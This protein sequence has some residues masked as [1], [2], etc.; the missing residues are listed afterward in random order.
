M[1]T[2]RIATRSSTKVTNPNTDSESDSDSAERQN[3]HQQQQQQQHRRPQNSSYRSQAAADTHTTYTKGA[4][5]SSL[6]VSSGPGGSFTLIQHRPQS[7]SSSSSP[8]SAVSASV[9]ASASAPISL[10]I[11]ESRQNID[12]SNCQSNLN[13]NN[14][15]TNSGGGSGAGSSESTTTTTGTGTGVRTT[16]SRR[17]GRIT[18]TPRRSESPRAL[19]QKNR[20][21]DF[22]IE[23]GVGAGVGV[24]VGVNIGVGMNHINRGDIQIVKS[25]SPS[26]P[27]PIEILKRNNNSSCSNNNTKS[28][29]KS[30]S[31]SKSHTN[32][33][34]K[35]KTIHTNTITNTK[36]SSRERPR[37]N[38]NPH[39]HQHTHLQSKGHHRNSHHHHTELNRNN[40]GMMEGYPHSLINSAP[41]AAPS[42]AISSSNANGSTSSNSGGASGSASS[43]IH[44]HSTPSTAA[45]NAAKAAM[46][47]YSNTHSHGHNH[48]HPD[49]DAWHR[50]AAAAYHGHG[51]GHPPGHPHPHGHSPAHNHARGAWGRHGHGHPHG[52]MHGHGHGHGRGHDVYE[53]N[54]HPHHELDREC[55][56]GREHERQRERERSLSHRKSEYESPNKVFGAPA[57]RPSKSTG[58]GNGSNGRGGGGGGGGTTTS[59]SSSSG[60]IQMRVAH[61]QNVFRDRHQTQS[62]NEDRSG[63][64]NSNTSGSG[65]NSRTSSSS[66]SSKSNGNTD[67]SPRSNII[68]NSDGNGNGNRS[69]QTKNTSKRGMT[70]I[71]TS[72][73]NIRG[74]KRS[75]NSNANAS[76]S[77]S[78]TTTIT[79]G[80]KKSNDTNTNTNNSARNKRTSYTFGSSNTSGTMRLFGSPTAFNFPRSGH[81]LAQN[82]VGTTF[83]Q[84]S[85]LTPSTRTG[86][87][88]ATAASTKSEAGTATLI[89]AVDTPTRIST[90]TNAF[91]GTSTTPSIN[92]NSNNKNSTSN[93]TK[94]SSSVFRE[95]APMQPFKEDEE[96]ELSPQDIL[97]SMRSGSIGSPVKTS[98][99]FGS[100]V[101]RPR[102]ASLTESIFKS[103][104]KSN[105]ETTKSEGDGFG[106][107][108]AHSFLSPQAPPQIQ[109]AHHQGG[110]KSEPLLFDPRTPKTPGSKEFVSST[111]GNIE[112]TPSFNLNLF[113]TSFDLSDANHFLQSPNVNDVHGTF[114]LKL[115]GDASSPRKSS[116]MMSSP[117]PFSRLSFSPGLRNAKAENAKMDSD[118]AHDINVSPDVG[119]DAV[120]MNESA[121]DS[122]SRTRKDPPLMPTPMSIQSAQNEASTSEEKLSSKNTMVLK[123]GNNILNKIPAPRYFNSNQSSSRSARAAPSSTSTHIRMG[124]PASYPPSQPQVY[125]PFHQSIHRQLLPDMRPSYPPTIAA[126]PHSK[127][128]YPPPTSESPIKTRRDIGRHPVMSSHIMRLGPHTPSTVQNISPKRVAPLTMKTKPITATNKHQVVSRPG[129]SVSHYK[130][131]KKPTSLVGIEANAIYTR[132]VDHRLAFEK[133]T[134]LLPGF[135]MALESCRLTLTDKPH[136]IQNENTEGSNSDCPEAKSESLTAQVCIYTVYYKSCFY[137]NYPSLLTFKSHY[138]LQSKAAEMIEKEKARKDLVVAQRRIESAICVFGGNCSNR[139]KKKQVAPDESKN[140]IFRRKNVNFES[141]TSRYSAAVANRF[142]EH[143]NRISWEFET[144]CPVDG[145]SCISRGRHTPTALVKR[146]SPTYELDKTTPKKLKEDENYVSSSSSVSSSRATPTPKDGDHPNKMR[147]RCKLCGQPKTNH[148]C[149]FK[150]SLLRS[151]GVN[152]YSAVNAYNATEPGKLAPALSEMNN[153]V[154]WADNMTDCTPA[155][156]SKSPLT[157]HPFTQ[158]PARPSPHHVTPELSRTMNS[159]NRNSPA[160]IRGYVSGAIHAQSGYKGAPRK[161]QIRRNGGSSQSLALVVSTP[162]RRIRRKSILSPQ[163]TDAPTSDSKVDSV[164]VEAA[165]LRQEQF[166]TVSTSSQSTFEYPSIPLPY[167]QRKSL[168]DNLFELSKEVPSLTDDCAGILRKAREEKMWDLAVA[169]LLSQVIVAIHCPKDDVRLEGLSRYLLSLG[170]SC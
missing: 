78:F 135:R 92:A 128:V 84:P 142:Y 91:R 35:T 147:Y 88:A 69:D 112:A 57:G 67:V 145:E 81:G 97:L 1:I 59:S 61:R 100:P 23:I 28:T 103:P 155:R 99:S 50:A 137:P 125:A 73:K 104:V 4:T 42:A 79:T 41:S 6:S 154:Q 106:V 124:H 58:R 11:A 166:R 87:A 64:G 56:R 152:V 47:Y 80:G 85:T 157:L 71:I 3:H 140:S 9:S 139:K 89:T 162:V 2:R 34:T 136:E 95:R 75:R 44:N 40:K 138:H 54:Y 76:G 12:F 38:T 115:S 72:S 90:N 20:A 123:P 86:A 10:S 170:I 153:F 161:K 33:H 63:D 7:S 96:T 102:S 53:A 169:E 105:R 21:R 46:G 168:S 149:P 108:Q 143:N 18:C 120:V 5:Q 160:P 66:S 49:E 107:E 134:Y 141:T 48:N 52:Y 15:A 37:T 126:T 159:T 74:A 130:S 39:Q 70:T 131:D 26:S 30:T 77:G 163:K 19:L 43:N 117:G 82:I 24:G 55:E 16:T 29:L 13:N 151:I 114:S 148:I 51:H 60:G 167:E 98:T 109:H 14:N 127:G 25:E 65:S 68:S 133:C 45:A 31:T 111:T 144:D 122:Q 150:K 165:H 113:G 36:S 93:A 132:L 146:K 110:N 101:R 119:L 17:G 164:F 62:R 22:G 129:E 8:G 118:L 94:T 83:N 116:L 156:P 32:I 121:P 27:I 158:T